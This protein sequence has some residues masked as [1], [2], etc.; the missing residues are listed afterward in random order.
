MDFSAVQR[1]LSETELRKDFEEFARRRRIKSN[2]RN[3]PSEDFFDKLVFRPKSGGKPSPC[4]PGLG[5]ILSQI[6][7]D[8][9]EKLVKDSPCINS[10]MTK[11]E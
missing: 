7:K 2:F 4:H 3:K 11:E 6:E 5:L 8:I 1:F 9:F 10:S